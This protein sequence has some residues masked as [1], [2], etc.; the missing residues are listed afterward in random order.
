MRGPVLQPRH[1]VPL[2]SRPCGADHW[3]RVPASHRRVLSQAAGGAGQEQRTFFAEK[4]S[5]FDPIR[6]FIR[7]IYADMKEIVLIRDPRDTYCSYRAFWSAAPSDA[8]Q[9]MRVLREVVGEIQQERDRNLM[10]LRYEDLLGD[11]ATALRRISDFLA[12]GQVIQP[13]PAAE[14]ELFR[15]HGTG[16]TAAASIGRWGA[17]LSADELVLFETEFGDLLHRFDYKI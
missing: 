9:A 5:L 4:C 7:A 17:E 10:F 11:P 6:N 16:E 2:L 14:A 1:V 15:M 8:M 3:A 13:D 12:L